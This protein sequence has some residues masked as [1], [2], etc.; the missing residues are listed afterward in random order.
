MSSSFK[1]FEPFPINS[2]YIN[3]TGSNDPAG[4]TSTA[5]PTSYLNKFVPTS[6]A[7]AAGASS[8]GMK[9]G[10]KRR[11][12]KNNMRKY[13]SMYR[14]SKRNGSGSGSKRN[15]TTRRIRIRTTR[16]IRR[17]KMRGGS[18]GD[19]ITGVS[20]NVTGYQMPGGPL[21][22]NMSALA[23]PTYFKTLNRNI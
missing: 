7:F 1:P 21:A 15:R 8:L 17:R 18:K 6:N 12:R 19:W 5:V 13:N 22:S 20:A 10:Y 11:S 3:S 16:R 4:F 14:K 9:G 23:N 2:K